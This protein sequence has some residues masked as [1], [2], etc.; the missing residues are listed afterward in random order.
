MGGFGSGWWGWHRKRD[1][2]EASLGLDLGLVTRGGPTPGK[3]GTLTW[4]RGDRQVAAV[5]YA[6]AGPADAPTVRLAYSVTRLGGE[7]RPV[8]L[9]VRLVRAAAPRGGHRWWGICPLACGGIVCSRRVGK[10]YLPLG[11]DLFGCRACHGLTYHARQ[12]HDKRVSRLARDPEGLH[13]LAA[14]S[15][16]LSV[17]QLGL[18]LAA[19]TELQKRYARAADRFEKRYGPFDDDPE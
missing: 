3:A 10:V 13:R 19:L 12:A 11:S 5:G 2:V 9:P 14:N 18:V 4:S 7:P 8:A 17:T 1:T 15:R 6:V 16:A